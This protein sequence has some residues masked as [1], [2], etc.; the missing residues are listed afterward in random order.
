MAGAI[1]WGIIGQDEAAPKILRVNDRAVPIKQDDAWGADDFTGMEQEMRLLHPHG[2]IGSTG[3]RVPIEITFPVP[4][5]AQRGDDAARSRIVGNAIPHEIAKVKVG[6]HQVGRQACGGDQFDRCAGPHHTLRTKAFPIPRVAV[7]EI[8][9]KIMGD[10]LQIRRNGMN[11]F[12]DGS[13]GRAPIG[14]V[15]HPFDRVILREG[16]DVGRDLQFCP[17]V[18]VSIMMRF[19]AFAWRHGFFG[20]LP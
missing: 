11:I 18:G 19:A 14:E 16:A 7:K 4:T 1:L 9:A 5:P 6:K 2:D 13:V 10:R 8:D 20:F 12:Q 3:G 17:R 15:E